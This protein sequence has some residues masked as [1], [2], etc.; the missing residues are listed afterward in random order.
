MLAHNNFTVV[1]HRSCRNSFTPGK[2]ESQIS[3]YWWSEW[4]TRLLVSIALG[5]PLTI[6]LWQRGDTAKPS[7][8]AAGQNS[9]SNT[10]AHDEPRAMGSPKGPTSMSA[11]QEGLSNADTMNPYVNEPGKSK[12]GEG[13]TETAKSI[14]DP[15]T[16]II[17]TVLLTGA[18]TLARTGSP[19]PFNEVFTTNTALAFSIFTF[20]GGAITYAR[21][22]SALSV[23]VSLG[24][25]YIALCLLSFMR[26]RAG[27]PYGAEIGL[28]ACLVVALVQILWVRKR[29]WNTFLEIYSVATYGVVVLASWFCVLS[30]VGIFLD[31]Y[32]LA[33]GLDLYEYLNR[34]G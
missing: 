19:Q 5:F 18:V 2:F 27:Q 17:Y 21:K 24:L 29:D 9:D 1:P 30:T 28:S 34:T 23:S 26:L 3:S 14:Q 7:N 20:L 13:E 6:Y 15:L 22:G 12:K 11:K 4:A 8:N 33:F 25:F 31:L 10:S 32:L 16:T